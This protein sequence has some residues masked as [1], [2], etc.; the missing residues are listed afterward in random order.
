MHVFF[1]TDGSAS[2]RFAQGQ[3]LAMPWR[4]PPHVT[5]MTAVHVQPPPFTSFVSSA[6]QAFDAELVTLRR[7]V[8]LR[9]EDILTKARAALEAS[10]TSV[11]TRMHAGPPGATIV[12]MARACRVDLVA[13]GSRGLGPYKGYLL[14]SVSDHIANH[15]RCSVLLAKTPPKRTGRYLLALDNSRY[16]VAV[17][18]W[19]RE[20]DLSKMARIH[21]VKVFRSMKEFPDPDGGDWSCACERTTPA[22]F[23]P[24]G[25]A[26]EVLE[27]MCEEGLDTDPARISVEVR[28]GQEVPEILAAVRQF[29]PDLLVVGA[30]GHY[31]TS[32]SPLGNVATKLVDHAPCSVLIVRPAGPGSH[33]HVPR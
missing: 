2:A 3:I 26:P 27:A 29:E 7:K 10:I 30:K 9:A 11:A 21:M 13:V 17:L 18:R 14:G 1:A 16:T 23:A 15:A 5:V 4:S 22:L 32:E 20:L 31:S 6:Q 12:E 33:G 8:E 25:N 28:F 19:L 24:W